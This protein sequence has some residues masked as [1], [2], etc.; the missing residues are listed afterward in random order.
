MPLHQCESCPKGRFNPTDGNTDDH[1]S[2]DDCLICGDEKYE[3]QPGASSCKDCSTN[4]YTEGDAVNDHDGVEDCKTCPA[5]TTF[6]S[7][8]THCIG[9][10]K[11]QY[12]ELGSA[13]Q[14]CPLGTYQDQ[15][16]ESQCKDCDVGM[17]ADVLAGSSECKFC[18]IGF[19]VRDV[20]P[21][22]ACS[23]CNA[24]KFQPSNDA[25]RVVS[26][27]L[28]C[29]KGRYQS[30]TG[31]ASCLECEPGTFQTS[32]VDSATSCKFCQAG[33]A[34]KDSLSLCTA[35]IKGQYQPSNSVAGVSCTVCADGYYADSTGESLCKPCSKGTYGSGD[36]AS[37]ESEN[38]HC[39]A[40]K[41]GNYTDQIGSTICKVCAAGFFNA[42]F[43]AVTC[44]ACPTAAEGAISCA[45]CLAGKAGSTST[46]C[47]K[48]VNGTYAGGGFQECKDCP[49]GFWS[50]SSS[51]SL[52]GPQTCTPC[53]IGKYSEVTKRV[54]SSACKPCAAG[55]FGEKAG[56]DKQTFCSDCEP[57]FYQKEPGA[58]GQASCKQCEPGR[59]SPTKGMDQECELCIMGMFLPTYGSFEDCEVCPAGWYNCDQAPVDRSRCEVCLPGQSQPNP[60]STSC[61]DCLPGQFSSQPKQIKCQDCDRG[62]Y[63]AEKGK[64]FCLS[65]LRGQYQNSS[66][67]TKCNDCK[68]NKFTDALRQYSCK[69]CQL[70][71]YTDVM[72][73]RRCRWCPAGKAG[74]DCISECETGKYRRFK[75]S[76]LS[77]LGCP[78]GWYQ[79]E[80]GRD[81]CSQCSTGQYA[82][83][84]NST[85]CK[86]CEEGQYSNKQKTHNCIECTEGEYTQDKG[87]FRCQACPTGFAGAGCRKC[88]AGMFRGAD[89]G[90]VAC[91][92]CD[93]GQYQN[94]EKQASCFPCVSGKYAFESGSTNCSSCP[95]GWRQKNEESRHCDICDDGKFAHKVGLSACQD[96]APGKFSKDSG[97]FSCEKCP[98]GW[99]Q[100]EVGGALCHVCATGQYSSEKG[101][102]ACQKCP[103]GFAGTGSKCD[104]CTKGKFATSGESICKDCNRGKYNEFNESASCLPCIPGRVNN[105]LGQTLCQECIPGKF[106]DQ[107]GQTSVSCKSCPSGFSQSGKGQTSCFEC[108]PGK[109]A[110][111]ESTSN[112]KDCP[113]G[114]LQKE[115][116]STTCEIVQPGS[117]VQ[118]G[119]GGSTEVAHGWHMT[120]CDALGHR[121]NSSEPCKAG[122]VGFIPANA[123]CALCTP[124]KFSY[125]GALQCQPCETSKYAAKS[126]AQTCVECEVAER[127]YSDVEG[128]TECK[129]CDIGRV[130]IGK[131]CADVALNTHLD[132]PPMPIVLCT[133]QSNR[134]SVM[135]S[136]IRSTQEEKTRRTLASNLG[137]DLQV[138]TTS[139]FLLDD[140]RQLFVNE[141][142]AAVTVRNV[143]NFVSYFRVRVVGADSHDVGSWSAITK[144]WMSTSGKAC[145]SPNAYL[146]ATSLTPTEWSCAECPTG[147]WCVGSV[148]WDDVIA[149]R[150]YWRDR[151]NRTFFAKCANAVACLGGC[152][153]D[154]SIDC[155]PVQDNHTDGCNE[156]AGY[157]RDCS[158]RS[159]AR[160]SGNPK[161][162]GGSCRLCST[163][164]S[165]YSLGGDGVTCL[166]CLTE[167]EEEKSNGIVAGIV[168]MLLVLL[169]FALLIFLK[170]K[171]STSGGHGAKTKAVHSTIKRIVLTHMQLITLCFS[172]RVPWPNLIVMMMNVFSSMS[173]V[174]QHALSLSCYSENHNSVVGRQADFLYLLTGMILMIPVFVSVMMY[175]WWLVFV[176]M[177]CCG[178][179]SC[180]LRKKLVKSHVCCCRRSSDRH[181]AVISRTNSY[182]NSIVQNRACAQRTHA[183]EQE[184]E[185]DTT[186]KTRD[187]WTYS[188]VLFV[189]MMFPSLVRFSMSL[190]SCRSID[191]RLNAM[192]QGDTP[193]YLRTDMEE[194]CWTGPHLL[195]VLLLALPGLLLY[196]IGIPLLTLLVLW[197]SR[198]YHHMNKYVFTFGLLYSGYRD[199]RWWWEI[200][201]LLR[202]MLFIIVTAF[203]Y[204]DS[205]QLHVMMAILIVAF[206][207]HFMFLPFHVRQSV[208]AGNALPGSVGGESHITEDGMLLHRLERNSLLALLLLMWSA[209]VFVLSKDRCDSYFCIFLSGACLASNVVFMIQGIRLFIKFFLIRT[210]IAQHVS[211]LFSNISSNPVLDRVRLSFN[212]D[213]GGSTLEHGSDSSQ[214]PVS[215]EL[216]NHVLESQVE[217]SLGK[218]SKKKGRQFKKLQVKLNPLMKQQPTEGPV[219]LKASEEVSSTTN[220]SEST[221]KVI[222]YIVDPNTGNEY[223]IDPVTG[224]AKWREKKPL[225]RQSRVGEML[226]GMASFGIDYL[227]D[228]A[229]GNEYYI[230]PVT[231]DA[232]WKEGTKWD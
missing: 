77:C 18:P 213:R 104:H 189:Y 96:C 140:T 173:T 183:E 128:S 82:Q 133:S 160:A 155:P 53:E 33:Q 169:I 162:A 118:V 188:V 113:L 194:L 28:S 130:S 200:V 47:T 83:N 4:T 12:A 25:I 78:Q 206:T 123:S 65:C 204:E 75:D 229:S 110:S 166:P 152:V 13:C 191:T 54:A 23:S 178:W 39:K 201:V 171:S 126:G 80:V 147:A 122:T 124:G 156:V 144:T 116:K 159:A 227:V 170:V 231:G 95:T 81:G 211:N 60:Q 62:E 150:G 180:G 49:E 76:P 209:N 215:I 136:W 175:V 41:Q 1:D 30:S 99:K 58:G 63:Q 185:K 37:K 161:D 223:Y 198:D 221:S 219:D 115:A 195:H 43:N 114:W 71:K 29:T 149:Q 154:N 165:G 125:E 174:S 232:K 87:N 38:A 22:S 85:T 168:I 210:K 46:D 182:R 15:L 66:Q 79:N 158:D 187:V 145:V 142:A 121:C 163:C 72:G 97:T 55:K 214:P 93:P 94:E 45:G 68:I 108:M 91:R 184:Q 20:L 109:F 197:R 105:E 32:D 59:W 51:S 24:G 73:S 137:Y 141:N 196:A 225:P 3:D 207:L 98:V 176:P 148:T 190:L 6:S 86:L 101:L 146:N 107:L 212:Y 50:A 2:L 36:A 164:R 21:R 111:S 26:D 117:I 177:S 153:G 102:S 202:K 67:A 172:L 139:A 222:K 48:C 64:T 92:K 100:K 8:G 208:D 27:C 135:V 5:G 14:A 70:G 157:Q 16:S 228:P 61:V 44:I 226:E 34:F 19:Y 9:C 74:E 69:K 84:E 138:S 56:A 143:Q 217:A 10:I 129:E 112:C 193:S 40:C 205:M 11:G 31:S 119:G 120:N 88:S 192:R 220:E 57:G 103:A 106:N 131:D 132:V 179:M 90:L 186:V 167:T 134:T 216:S 199:D 224:V 181:P 52:I 35:C 127:K 7:T 203:L 151:N 89:D 230:D 17:Y 42:A 218:K